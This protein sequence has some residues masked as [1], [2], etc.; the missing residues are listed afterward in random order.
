M[1]G[2]F[3][4]GYQHQGVGFR[5]IGKTGFSLAFGNSS[6][7]DAY[8]SVAPP[9]IAWYWL[10]TAEPTPNLRIA[11]ITFGNDGHDP[12]RGW[13]SVDI[14]FTD[15]LDRV[16]RFAL[17]ILSEEHGAVIREASPPKR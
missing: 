7:Y 2:G 3:G 6:F 15:D 14:P 9:L 16:T 13:V 10:A 17:L 11:L 5:H 4:I 8:W 1:S 12:A